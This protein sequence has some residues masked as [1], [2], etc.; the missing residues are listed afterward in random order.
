MHHPLSISKT[1]YK[2]ARA[3]PAKLYY[4]MNKYPSTK[5]GDEYMELLAEG[6]YMIGAIASL[7][8]DEAVL[9]DEADHDKAVALTKLTFSNKRTSL[10]LKRPSRARANLPA[11]M[12]LSNK[13]AH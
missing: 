11:L 10:R 9:V 1:D 8:F 7:L 6:G 4:R 2:V 13:A 3:C 5:D 12:C